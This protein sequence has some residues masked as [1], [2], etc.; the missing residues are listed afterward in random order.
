MET[1]V[2]LLNVMESG[3][4]VRPFLRTSKSLASSF[5]MATICVLFTRFPYNQTEMLPV[6]NCWPEQE[7]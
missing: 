6:K 5:R 3:V 2:A 4:G 7:H 1:S